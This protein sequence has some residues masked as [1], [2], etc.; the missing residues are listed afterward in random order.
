MFCSKFNYLSQEPAFSGKI[1]F[2]FFL[3]SFFQKKGKRGGPEGGPEGGPDRRPKGGPEGV[4]MG[5]KRG[6]SRGSR[7]GGPRF[8]PT[9]KSP[10]CSLELAKYSLDK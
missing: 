10:S 3:F 8:V 7:L 9:R 6:S 5:S 4:Q 2:T 1:S